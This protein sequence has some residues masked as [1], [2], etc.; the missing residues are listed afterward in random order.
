MFRRPLSFVILGICLGAFAPLSLR[1]VETTG[2]IEGMVADPTGAVVPGVKVTLTNEGT[3]EVKVYPTDQLGRFV[4]PNL[5]VGTY[6]LRAEKEGFKTFVQTKTPVRVSEHLNLTVQLELGAVATEVE[7]RASV[8][9]VDTKSAAL[10]N[11]IE[12]RAVVDLPL[13]GRNFLQLATLVAGSTPAIG[14]SLPANPETPGGITSSPQVNGLRAESNNY[15]L[16]GADNNEPFL[17]SAAVVPSA[18]AIQEFKVET[19]LYN[20]E[21]GSSAGAIVNVV[22]KSGTNDFHGSVYEFFRND[23][24]D[25]R[26]FFSPEV[27]VLKRNQFGFSVGGPIVRGRTFFFG[28]YEGF[29]QRSA[30]T[31]TASVPTLLERQGN[32]SQSAVQPIDPLTGLPFPGGIIPLARFHPI[33]VNLLP[34]YPE[35]NVGDDRVVSSPAVPSNNDQVLV[36]V[37]HK[38][39]ENDNLTVR[40]FFQDGDGSFEFVPS[41]L[42]AIDVPGFPAGDKFRFHNVVI[43]NTHTFSPTTILQSHFSYNR[44][45]LVAAAAQFQFD[46]Q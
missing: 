26:N 29:R 31:R 2:T 34:F 3:G 38:L 23:A 13:N 24:L 42:G 36:R 7:V 17:G 10:G 43:S 33:S 45:D 39:R 27:P 44:A 6:A 18:E 8:T 35:P 22:T 1:A 12:N 5:P 46:A 20:A 16:D 40:Y 41:F 14:Y 30:E 9:T 19:N 25:A 21:F 15:L 32:F 4:F 28:N 37:D 11:V